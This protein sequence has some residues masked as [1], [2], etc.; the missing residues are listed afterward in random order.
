M[1]VTANA[2]ASTAIGE[3]HHRLIAT[4]REFASEMEGAGERLA[5]P[6]VVRAAIAF[7]RESLLPFAHWEDEQFDGCPDV[8]EESAFE[9][10]FLQAEIDALAAAVAESDRG[11]EP[12]GLTD[13]IRRSVHRIEAVLELHVQ[14]A[15][16]RMTLRATHAR[17]PGL[18][19]HP[20]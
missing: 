15:D 16:E 18:R 6:I 20:R 3:G 10:A 8:A 13:R 14:K 11:E 12:A 5:D 19:L 17:A 2:C 9:H 1:S 4:F 7:L